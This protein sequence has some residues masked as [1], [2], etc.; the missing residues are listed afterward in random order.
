MFHAHA[1]IG[2]VSGTWQQKDGVEAIGFLTR[3]DCTQCLKNAAHT[4]ASS[5]M[6]DL[7]AKQHTSNLEL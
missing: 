5:F 6:F 4:L 3:R 2:C 7:D 1:R